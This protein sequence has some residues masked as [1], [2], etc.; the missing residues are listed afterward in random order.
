MVVLNVTRESLHNRF[1][2]LDWLHSFRTLLLAIPPMFFQGLKN[3]S[4]SIVENSCFCFLIV[5]AHGLGNEVYT[6]NNMNQFVGL[7]FSTAAQVRSPI[8]C[9]CNVIDHL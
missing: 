3:G 9:T 7:D 1:F 2:V 6:L 5:A 4:V 8:L